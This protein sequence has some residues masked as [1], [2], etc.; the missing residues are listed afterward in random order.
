MALAAPTPSALR[1]EKTGITL[2]PDS[3][4]GIHLGQAFNYHVPDVT[5]ETGKID[6]VWAAEKPEPKSVYN[7]YYYPFDRN[8]NE[9][10][11]SELYKLEWFKAHH[12]DWIVY[13][14][15]AANYASQ[16]EVPDDAVAWE[17][18][19]RGPWV[20]LDI[21]N[22]AVLRFMFDTYL[23]P[24]IGRGYPA[25]AFDNVVL[26]NAHG[27][28]G[29]WRDGRWVRQYSGETY[30]DPAF[31]RAVADW[32]EWMSRELHAAGGAMAV[33]LTYNPALAQ[34]EATLDK[35][36]RV[37]DIIVPEGGTEHFG[38]G[39]GAGTAADWQALIGWLRHVQGDGKPL[40]L[41]NYTPGESLSNRDPQANVQ[42]DLANYLLLKSRHTYLS[43]QPLP[44]SPGAQ[45]GKK[46]G[47]LE[48][49]RPEFFAP[50]GHPVGDMRQE[51]EAFLR[52]YSN[53]K[54]IVNPSRSATVP[55]AIDPNAW[56]D[57]Y[58]NALAALTLAP[59]SAIV[60]LKNDR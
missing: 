23:R 37:V 49:L 3:I 55:V 8:L 38:R 47:A 39:S 11:G 48:W 31:I 36:A 6:L 57:L 60:L 20:P 18:N 17:F 58:G 21:S 5:A 9:R 4:E 54:A 50:V 14:C 56:R 32:A 30:G 22:A 19:N 52:D 24:A 34:A 26:G 40:F 29:I 42:W 10:V 13:T 35:V 2:P 53:G 28:C 16:Q 7:M 27:R 51:G 15:R 33:N 59:Q 45:E 1:A 25:I 41:L 43:V 44:G 12:P 46:E